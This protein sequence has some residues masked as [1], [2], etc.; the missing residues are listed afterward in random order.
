MPEA[1]EMLTEAENSCKL[2]LK[3]S[4][5]KPNGGVATRFPPGLEWEILLAD[6]VVFNGLIHALNESYAGFV[7]AL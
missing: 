7:K 2:A 4:K 6:V 5:N 1:A 3:S